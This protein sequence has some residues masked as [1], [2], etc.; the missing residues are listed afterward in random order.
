MSW[1]ALLCVGVPGAKAGFIL[2][3][4]PDA[5]YYE[6]DWV[7]TSTSPGTISI[8]SPA[9]DPG[10]TL[11]TGTATTS[12]SV[13]ATAEATASN[14]SGIGG[15]G[16][17]EYYW[18][19]G[20]DPG[21]ADCDTTTNVPLILNATG[22][23]DASGVGSAYADIVLNNEDT[24]VLCVSTGAGP[25]AGPSASNVSFDFNGNAGDVSDIY[26]V[27]GAVV[28]C[29][30]EGS[31]EANIDPLLSIDPGFLASHPDYYLTFSAN[32]DLG[33]PEPGAL[34]LAATGLCALA[35]IRRR[36]LN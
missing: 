36:R 6:D 18:E 32:S 33:A 3:P 14:G 2:Q 29:C 35:A 19:I 9:Q 4:V 1:F 30:A 23:V 22:S 31:A 12:G 21:A 15:Q 10:V 26:M 24:F 7:S 34:L 5:T 8:S 13:A 27:A 16:I 25:C 17:A 11:I 20:C 28:D